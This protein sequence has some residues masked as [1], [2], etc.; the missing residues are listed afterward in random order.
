MALWQLPT[1]SFNLLSHQTILKKTNGLSVK[2]RCVYCVI[3][4]LQPSS[5]HHLSFISPLLLTFLSVMNFLS[6]LPSQ[7]WTHINI[8]KLDFLHLKFEAPW[9]YP[10]RLCYRQ[11]KSKT[12]LL[13]ANDYLWRCS[14][15]VTL[16]LQISAC[17]AVCNKDRNLSRRW[18]RF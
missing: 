16:P 2:P 12:R 7:T 6:V 15:F 4:P 9:C 10:V 8:H 14:S 13:S 11:Y 18:F 1:A 5:V 17:I 3:P